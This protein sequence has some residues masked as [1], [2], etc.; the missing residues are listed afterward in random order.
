MPLVFVHGLTVRK[1]EGY[2]AA[3]RDRNRLF[4]GIA[5]TGISTDPKPTL[6]SPYWGDHAAKFPFN[7]GYLPSKGVESLGPED[8]L[9]LRL[10]SE[11]TPERMPPSDKAVLEVARRS[12]P[13]AVDLLWATSLRVAPETQA[14]E[15]AAAGSAAAAYALAN[16][17]PEWLSM[18]ENDRELL[19]R[20]LE[21]LDS[22]QP[23]PQN[24]AEA[25]GPVVESLG[26]DDLFN[27]LV[28]GLQ[29]ITGTVN[30]ATG[31]LLT[32]VFREHLNRQ[33][34]TFMGDVFIYMNARGKAD[35]LET[36]V[37]I[38]GADVQKAAAARKPGDNRLILVGHSMGGNILYDILTSFLPDIEVDALVTVGAQVGLFE[39]LR[40]FA[41]SQAT[42]AGSPPPKVKRPPRVK[43][44][45]NIYDSADPLGFA[46]EKIFEGVKDHSFVTGENI[47]SS[48]GSYFDRTTFHQRLNVR[49]RNAFSGTPV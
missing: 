15:L 16:P 29:R 32:D 10:L 28:G 4:Q 3:E 34:A 46:T 27:N 41:A 14:A 21:E 31:T 6:L 2:E 12:L 38:V 11:A 24:D 44:W 23:G 40:L 5:L 25:P 47:L 1:G 17:R 20:L 18:V 48:H 45:I 33:I 30:N 42:A 36:I 19:D 8:E 13:Q 43:H 22:F 39:E 35:D 9:T 49:L 37:G 26:F 7:H